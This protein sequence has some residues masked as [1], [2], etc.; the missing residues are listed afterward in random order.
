MP[1]E[2]MNEEQSI[3]K[4]AAGI[5]KGNGAVTLDAKD[6]KQVLS[7]VKNLEQALAAVL[8]SSYERANVRGTAKAAS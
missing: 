6:A 2:L 1:M 7:R 8:R 4:L 5:A 3:L